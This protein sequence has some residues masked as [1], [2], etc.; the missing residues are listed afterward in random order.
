LILYTVNQELII[1][2]KD[3]YFRLL[4]HDVDVKHDYSRTSGKDLIYRYLNIK[5][6]TILCFSSKNVKIAVVKIVCGSVN[7]WRR[8]K[9]A[10]SSVGFWNLCVHEEYNTHSCC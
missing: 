2:I 3:G 5:L 8:T 10:E 4:I 9:A 1:I 6:L 7:T